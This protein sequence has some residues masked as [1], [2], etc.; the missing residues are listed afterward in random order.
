MTPVRDGVDAADRQTWA[1]RRFFHLAWP[2]WQ[3]PGADGL[4]AIVA[5]GSSTAWADG[6]LARTGD[7]LV[8][9]AATG[10][11]P[12]TQGLARLGYPGVR[13]VT[14][15]PAKSDPRRV[16]LA[17]ELATDLT[18]T[19]HNGACLTSWAAPATPP[20]V[21]R[22]P[23]LITIQR[24]GGI[25]DT[26][27]WELARLAVAQHW[28][29]GPLPDQRF[30][31]AHLDALLRLRGAARRGQLPATAVAAGLTELIPG[32]DLSIRVVYAHPATFRALLLGGQRDGHLS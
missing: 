11:D 5:A 7:G 21:V 20:G 28:L 32:R 29:S 13:A 4:A 25:T 31:E 15:T 2:P 26:V 10:S 23:H 30:F 14:L 16:R 8:V 9:W 19:R 1:S 24:D 12:E 6:L 27:V 18:A 17:L 22:I 3:P